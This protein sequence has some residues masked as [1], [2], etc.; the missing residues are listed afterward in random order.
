MEFLEMKQGDRCAHQGNGASGDEGARVGRGVEPMQKV[1]SLVRSE[2]NLDP[3]SPFS[4]L[5][6]SSFLPPFVRPHSKVIDVL[7]KA[8]EFLEMKVRGSDVE[9]MQKVF[10]LVRHELNL[11][12]KNLKQETKKF[13]TRFPAL[14][15][16]ELLLLAQLTRQAD[17]VPPE[18][19][20]DF[21]TILKLTPRLMEELI[22]F[23]GG[24][25]PS[26]LRPFL[27]MLLPSHATVGSALM[28]FPTPPPPNPRPAH[29][30]LRHVLSSSFLP[31]RSLCTLIYLYP[32]PPVGYAWL[33]PAVGAIELPEL[34]SGRALI[35]LYPRPPV[36]YAWLRPAVGAIELSQ[37]FYQ[38]V[39]L[40]ARKQTDKGGSAE[41]IAAL[42]QLPHVDEGVV[43]KL[44]RKVS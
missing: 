10:S 13:W 12:P 19:R 18:L 22:K 44:T 9:P 36:G 39:P 2:L 6:P 37:S 26:P 27:S 16:V 31:H 43:K 20:K 24:T 21:N 4:S 30:F 38:A 3:T 5:S 35:S 11:D 15:K 29:S 7:T 33:R 17:L 42:L 34:L 41:G 14:I 8:M 32:R 40:S 25:L 28:L 23:R 1:F